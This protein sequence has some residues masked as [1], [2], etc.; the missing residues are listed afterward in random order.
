C[1]VIASAA[2]LGPVIPPSNAMIVYALMA[3]SSVSIGGLFMA[4]IVPGLILAIGF[5]GIASYISW[6]RKY[7]ATGEAFNDRNARI[8][9]REAYLILLVLILVVGG[10]IGRVFTA[11]EGAAIA[12]TYS[13]LLGL[14]VTRKLKL[15]D[16]P[17]CLIRAAISAAMVAALMAFAATV[18]FLLTID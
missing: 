15:S 8:Q 18:T 6:K 14:F 2:N 1:A 9:F 13:T 7:P 17:S 4:G 10:I 5:M 11:T 12:V 3:G 16:L